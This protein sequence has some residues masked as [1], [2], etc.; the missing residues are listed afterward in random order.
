[1]CEAW[2][3]VSVVPRGGR[4]RS[5]GDVVMQVFRQ[6]IEGSQVSGQVRCMVLYR[7]NICCVC[8]YI[9]CSLVEK[10]LFAF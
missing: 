9:W 4:V 2:V 7:A 8:S 1:M 3:D 10:L 5:G 6:C